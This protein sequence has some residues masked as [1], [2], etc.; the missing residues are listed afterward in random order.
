MGNGKFCAILT[1]E[2]KFYIWTLKLTNLRI[3]GLTSRFPYTGRCACMFNNVCQ[4]GLRHGAGSFRVS[5]QEWGP[6]LLEHNG[7][8]PPLGLNAVMNSL[9][10]R[11]VTTRIDGK[12]K[13]CI[14]SPLRVWVGF[15]RVQWLSIRKCALNRHL[16]G[17]KLHGHALSTVHLRGAFSPSLLFH[18]AKWDLNDDT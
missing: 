15:W 11:S 2:S 10:V 6:L 9:L 5:L 12:C 13:S 14:G 3:Y 17:S 4:T 1:T 8:K 18:N 7:K 16:S